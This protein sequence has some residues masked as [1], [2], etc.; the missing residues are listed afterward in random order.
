MLPPGRLIRYDDLPGCAAAVVETAGT[1]PPGA[2][3]SHAI[4]TVVHLG[5]GLVVLSDRFSSA[6][7]PPPVWRIRILHGGLADG[8]VATL[9]GRAGVTGRIVSAEGD[10]SVEPTLLKRLEHEIYGHLETDW[11]RLTGRPGDSAFDLVI[12]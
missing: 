10:F 7:P 1:Y 8:R 12:S 4:R 6:C 5:G 2:E 11:L 9:V 3:V